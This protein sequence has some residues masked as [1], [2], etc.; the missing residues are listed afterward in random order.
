MRSTDALANEM[1]AVFRQTPEGHLLDCNELCA[2]MLGYATCDELLA[3]GRF[4]YQNP[5]D[6]TAV[7]TLRLKMWLRDE[8]L[9]ASDSHDYM[10]E[11]AK[12]AP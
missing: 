11:R 3:T 1:V 12:P 9:A 4:E 8:F 5:S 7:A 6:L 2:Q 10:A